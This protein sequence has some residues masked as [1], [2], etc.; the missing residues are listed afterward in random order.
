MNGNSNF[1][2]VSDQSENDV[3]ANGAHLKMVE[4]AVIRDVTEGIIPDRLDGMPQLPFNLMKSE[5]LVWLIEDVEY[6][7][8]KIRRER[9]GMSRGLSIR[10]VKGLYYRP[11]VFKSRTIETEEQLYA[12]TGLLGITSKH[13]YFHGLR[14]RF[15]IRLDRIVSFEPYSDGIGITRDTQNALPET[16]ITG[17]GW[18][19]YNLVANLAQQC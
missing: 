18:F 17:D 2:I 11:S 12:D 14:K 13:I 6:Y 3:D 15:R 4:A 1:T 10:I 7:Q 8:V 19:L 5:Q 16:F 9:R